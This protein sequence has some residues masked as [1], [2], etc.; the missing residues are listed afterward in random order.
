MAAGE[1]RTGGWPAVVVIGL[2][3]GV[4]FFLNHWIKKELKVTAPSEREASPVADPE[5]SD[6]SGDPATL[7]FDPGENME[8]KK[9]SVDKTEKKRER[10]QEEKII[11][12]LPISEKYLLQ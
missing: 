7:E 6:P 2:L 1:T 9:F 10:K 3:L 12:E 8:M 4:N 5:H 11:Y